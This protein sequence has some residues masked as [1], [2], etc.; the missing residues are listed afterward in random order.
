MN[1]DW[2]VLRLVVFPVSLLIA[3]ASVVDLLHS[4][5]PGTVFDTALMYLEDGGEMI[6]ILMLTM[7]SLYL[8]R[9]AH[10]IYGEHRLY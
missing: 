10:S 2:T 5:L 6:A 4:A 9:N 8:V 1:G 3:C 7:I